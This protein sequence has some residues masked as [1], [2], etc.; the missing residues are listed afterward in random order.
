MVKVS[1]FINH[2]LILIFQNFMNHKKNKTRVINRDTFYSI[3]LFTIRDTW[4]KK[5]TTTQWVCFLFGGG[6]VPLTL[7]ETLAVISILW[8]LP[9]NHVK[10]L[11]SF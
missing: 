4:R 10:G 7:I 5:H 1:Q 6:G 11:F 2:P 9:N 8:S 3:T